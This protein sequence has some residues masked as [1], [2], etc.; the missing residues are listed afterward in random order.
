MGKGRLVRELHH[1]PAPEVGAQTRVGGSEGGENVLK[2]RGV[3][4]FPF[5]RIA[6]APE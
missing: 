3:I 4:S 6:L 2:S 5:K 1:N